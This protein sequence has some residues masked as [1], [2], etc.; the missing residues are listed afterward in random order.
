MYD[1]KK[2]SIW[3]KVKCTMP[4]LDRQLKQIHMYVCMYESM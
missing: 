4:Q 2:K 1:A 3:L